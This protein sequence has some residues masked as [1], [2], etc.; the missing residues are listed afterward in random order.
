ENRWVKRGGADFAV[1]LP[2]GGPGMPSPEQALASHAP[3]VKRQVFALDG[4]GTVAA[5]SRATDRGGRGRLGTRTRAPLGPARG[6]GAAVRG[7]RRGGGGG[8]EGR[9]LR[10][11]NGLQYLECER[12]A[13][14]EG[15]PPRG[16][17]FVLFQPDGG[18][19]LKSGGQDMSLPLFE[20][21]PDPRLGSPKL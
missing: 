7:G 13:P 1:P 10:E 20:A 21:E 2:N 9:F 19:W 11:K 6:P 16:L 8:G 18:D 15:P 14:A 5:A 3:G 17:R 4:A 12:P